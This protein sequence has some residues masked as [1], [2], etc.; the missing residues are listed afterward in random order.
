MIAVLEEGA[1]FLPLLL[2]VELNR[3]GGGM[4]ALR[5]PLDPLNRVSEVT[6]AGIGVIPQGL[7][8]PRIPCTEDL[9]DEG[10]S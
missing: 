3:K 4:S 8:C 5:L 9:A 10:T 6:Q 7:R 1:K 2:F